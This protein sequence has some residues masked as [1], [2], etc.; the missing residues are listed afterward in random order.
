MIISK[1]EK[2]S[3]NSVSILF[4]NIETNFSF[5]KKQMTAERNGNGFI[6]RGLRDRK[7]REGQLFFVFVY[8]II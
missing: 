5:P 1:V 3:N 6:G 8:F 7:V 2:S 4:R